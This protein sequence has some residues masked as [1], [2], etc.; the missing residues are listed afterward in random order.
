MLDRMACGSLPSKH[1]LALRGEDG[2]LHYEECLTREGFEGPYTI[3]YHR[4]RPHSLQPVERAPQNRAPA[5]EHASHV[6]LRRRHFRTSQVSGGG[7][8][9]DAR[10]ALLY[11][12]DL[13]ISTTRPTQS[14]RR[15]RLNA[16]ADEL[17]FVRSGSGMLRSVLGDLRF[18]AL[19]YLFVPKGLIH[20]FE[21]EPGA[22]HELLALECRRGVN[23][24]SQWRNASGQL[25]MDAPY[26][27][28]DFR[29]P[30]FSG[31]LD[32]G[33]RELIIKRHDAEHAF[34]LNGSPLDVVG[35]DGVV[36]PWVFPI[37]AFQPRVS[38]VHL[39]PTWHGTFAA[40]GALICSFV[41]RPVEFHPQAIPCPY[42]HTSVDI[43]EV[44][45]YVSGEFT[46]RAG[47]GP[48]SLTLHPRGI[49][50]GPQPG[51]YEQ[52]VGSTHTE[53]LAVMLDCRLP[54]RV[55]GDAEDAED[56]SYERGLR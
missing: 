22:P 13:T 29:R 45:Y 20:R 16:D 48:G 54:L 52:S 17:Y 21:L 24:P 35:W 53:E 51:K 1:H 31:P 9:D 34:H 10:V 39:P 6:G 56:A 5:P 12:E 47:V 14:D 37:L 23:I 11:N 2:S 15:Y 44:L 42:A 32:E 25:R 50:H 26:C 28:R 38:S 8:L 18:G 19:D 41:P 33:M 3:L 27:H 4:A 55:S 7:T 46:S 49:P 30:E 40:G 36:Y 43:D